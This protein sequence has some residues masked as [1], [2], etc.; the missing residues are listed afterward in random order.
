MVAR[1]GT[2]FPGET[3]MVTQVV[4]AIKAVVRTVKNSGLYEIEQDAIW[5]LSGSSQELSL[6]SISRD[7]SPRGKTPTVANISLWRSNNKTSW[8][9]SVPLYCFLPWSS[10]SKTL[11]GISCL[12][13]GGETGC[14]KLILGTNTR[15]S[16]NFSFAYD[17]Y[18]IRF[19]FQWVLIKQVVPIYKKKEWLTYKNSIS[20]YQV[21]TAFFPD[22]HNEAWSEHSWGKKT[23][24]LFFGLCII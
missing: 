3:Q 9:P 4:W 23:K 18:V 17:G 16:P 10:F 6:F 21:K 7:K 22:L 19:N 15:E 20:R 2:I 13:H 12:L 14:R 1:Q 24:E 8:L 11:R 5:H